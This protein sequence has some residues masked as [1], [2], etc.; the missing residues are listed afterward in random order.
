MFFGVCHPGAYGV[1]R[2]S[3][4][5]CK[6][7]RGALFGACSEPSDDGAEFAIYI[8]TDAIPSEYRIPP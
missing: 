6:Q 1:P 4:W 8:S 2:Y 7:S 3:L 5:P